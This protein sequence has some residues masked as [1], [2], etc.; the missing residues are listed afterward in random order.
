ME[1]SRQTTAGETEDV[2]MDSEAGGVDVEREEE[3]GDDE[4]SNNTV[5]TVNVDGD[6]LHICLSATNADP[7]L[8]DYLQMHPLTKW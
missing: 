6:P 7:G 5:Q 4:E 2:T 8:I 3:G 1:S